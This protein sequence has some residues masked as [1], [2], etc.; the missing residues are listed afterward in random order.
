MLT[1]HNATEEAKD[2]VKFGV[3]IVILVII[4]IIL[5]PFGKGVYNSMF[6]KPVSLPAAKFGKLPHIVF[7]ENS[8]QKD[9]S[10]TIDTLPGVLPTFADRIAVYQIPAPQPNLLA[11]ERAKTRVA[12][13]GFTSNPTTLTDSLYEWIDTSTLQR[14]LD[15]DILSL[16]F[17]LGSN[18][19]SPDAS[20]SAA[21][22][23]TET[24]A[25]SLA[26]NF[27][28]KLS[29]FPTDIDQ[30][31]TNIT[32]YTIADGKLQE[33]PTRDTAQV[34][35]VSFFQNNLTEHPIYYPDA[36]FSNMNL[37]VGGGD[38]IVP[39][40]LGGLFAHYTP[41]ASS[42]YGIKTAQQAFEDLKNKKGYIASYG[43]SSNKISITDV[44]LGY[45]APVVSQGY[46]LPIIVFEGNDGFLGYVEAVSDSYLTN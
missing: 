4:I 18:Y 35:R 21:A 39:T 9:F 26:T 33:V 10:Y 22:L 17:T 36:P 16:N 34:V 27:I 6:P 11:L 45:L 14:Q 8:L 13:V 38:Q 31:K 43:G 24:D 46:F 29:S 2:L 32:Y 20:I 41:D 25:I 15:F 30:G 7:P 3:F 42:P 40:V 5:F 23:P 37:L 28:N 1:L 44:K 19:L 12:D